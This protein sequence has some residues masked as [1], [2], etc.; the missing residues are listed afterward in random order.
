MVANLLDF[1]RT[2]S[3]PQTTT[4]LVN[5]TLGSCSTD[6]TPIIISYSLMS[7]LSKK[8]PLK[9]EIFLNPQSSLSRQLSIGTLKN[10]RRVWKDGVMQ[11]NIFYSQNVNRLQRMVFSCH[12]SFSKY[13]IVSLKGGVW[14]FS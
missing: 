4:D 7:R 10:G 13:S 6:V 14:L 8:I 12:S 1:T 11:R 5:E 9:Q 3:V 2:T